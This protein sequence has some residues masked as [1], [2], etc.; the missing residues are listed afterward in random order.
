MR[1]VR[2]GDV[3]PSPVEADDRG[4][5]AEKTFI[6]VLVPDGP[7]FVLRLFTVAPG[8]HTPLHAHD[9]EHG[10]YIVSGAGKTAG[11]VEVD[12]SAGDALYVAPGDVH[13]LVCTGKE[14]L[15]FICVVPQ[16]P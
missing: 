15:E 6:Q 5:P 4:V 12:F 11:G 16:K 14:P 13:S 9:W 8:G 10:V 1:I 7:N 3:R 2:K